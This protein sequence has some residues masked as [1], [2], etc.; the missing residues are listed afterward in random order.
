MLLT[1]IEVRKLF[2]KSFL[3]VIAG[4]LQ[5]MFKAADA[6]LMQLAID[7]P[8][9]KE[10]NRYF[11]AVQGLRIEKR[12]L[13]SRFGVL[14]LNSIDRTIADQEDGEHVA[15]LRKLL[16]I[17]LELWRADT[18]LAAA[19]YDLEQRLLY[20]DVTL[21]NPLDPVHMVTNFL[22]ALAGAHVDIH[23]KLLMLRLFEGQLFYK[24]ERYV[25]IANDVLL[26][27]DVLPDLETQPSVMEA[28]INA[29]VSDVLGQQVDTQTQGFIFLL[30]EG[31]VELQANDLEKI[32]CIL[33]LDNINTKQVISVRDLIAELTSQQLLPE[34]LSESLALHT[35]KIQLVAKLFQ[36]MMDDFALPIEA[37]AMLI[38]LQLPYAR[39]ALADASILQNSQHPART[40]LNQMCE[41]LTEWQP[42][43]QTLNDD[44]LFI[45]L[46]ETI[47]YFLEVE[48]ITTINYQE[49]LF[50]Y[51][52]YAEGQRQKSVATSKRLVDAQLGLDIADSVRD[53]VNLLLDKKMASRKVPGSVKRFLLEGWCHVLY[54]TAMQKGLAA[55]EWQD[56]IQVVDDL[57]VSVCQPESFLSRSEFVKQ[58]QPLL[59]KIRMGLMDIDLSISLIN[60]MLIDLEEDHKRAVI[61]IPGDYAD[62]EKIVDFRLASTAHLYWQNEEN[63][64]KEIKKGVRSG[65]M[66]S[67]EQLQML[68]NEAIEVVKSSSKPAFSEKTLAIMEKMG[69]GVFLLW[70]KEGVEVRCRVAAHIKHTKKFIITDRSGVKLADL[71]ELELTEKIDSGEVRIMVGEQLFDRA[72]ESVIGGMRDRR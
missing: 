11:E 54:I 61:N 2:E 58:L 16:T 14:F 38:N 30:E 60:Q 57:V 17:N 64:K 36:Y 59:R 20:I 52:A 62:L 42:S 32:D 31:L 72:L 25:R 29:I 3:P 10:K 70:L 19:H 65:I 46:R 71:L 50:R 33:Q 8:T 51:L 49:F 24:L 48:R 4:V 5:Q 12:D 6:A 43:T 22:R 45:L 13:I 69:P 35:E 37:K 18:A 34:V 67:V 27:H 39:V 7:A 47:Q 66:F 68:A 28:S 63:S 21:K 53:T 41:V 55:K 9:N 56:T 40:L 1:T 15:A 44:T 23:T 26:E